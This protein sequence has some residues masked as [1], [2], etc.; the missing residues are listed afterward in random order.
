MKPKKTLKFRLVDILIRLSS[1][2]T[3][4]GGDHSLFAVQVL[5]YE[6]NDKQNM[7]RG[8]VTV[9]MVDTTAIPHCD[10]MRIADMIVR[11]AVVTSG[12]PIGSVVKSLAEYHNF[13]H[14]GEGSHP[15]LVN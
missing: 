12:G 4:K 10:V 13:H 3:T 7:R 14:T 1:L 5:A 15:P 9:S 11:S 8:Q 6:E 2:L